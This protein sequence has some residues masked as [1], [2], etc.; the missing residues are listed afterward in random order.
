MPWACARLHAHRPPSHPQWSRNGRESSRLP[1]SR[2]RRRRWHWRGLDGVDRDTT[3]CC[4]QVNLSPLQCSAAK[5]LVM[6][7]LESA[8]SARHGLRR[9]PPWRGLRRGERGHLGNSCMCIHVMPKLADLASARSCAASS[10]G[11]YVS[12]VAYCCIT[13]IHI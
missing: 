1:P 8:S 12:Y 13:H 7:L 6:M 9:R 4:E 2:R 11:L 5:M 3:F 10:G